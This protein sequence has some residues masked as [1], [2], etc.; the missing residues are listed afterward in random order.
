MFKN[1]SASKSKK[2]NGRTRYNEASDTDKGSNWI[3]KNLIHWNHMHSEGL[4]IPKCMGLNPGHSQRGDWA[5]TE[6]GFD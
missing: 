3:V 6:T 4:E 5:S 2:N 1:S